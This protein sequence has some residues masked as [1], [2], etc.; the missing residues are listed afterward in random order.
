M[1]YIKKHFVIRSIKLFVSAAAL[2]F[3]AQAQ[4]EWTLNKDANGIKVY[5]KASEGS[6][7]KSIRATL[8]FD[9]PIS[10]VLAV[11]GDVKSFPEWV[12]KCKQTTLLKQISPTSAMFHHITEA[13]WPF[14]SRDHVSVYEMLRDDKTG[15]VT[16]KSHVISGVYP[17][18]KGY[19]RLKKSH[20][21]WIFTPV[22]DNKVVA[23]YE[24][25]FDPEGNIPAWLINMF[26]TEGPFQSLSKLKKRVHEQKYLDA[27][28]PFKK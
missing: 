26:I 14:D 16:M 11:V 25:S 15:V 3:Y 27:P 21:S 24:L 28:S 17:E 23:V 12:Y 8:E 5:T 9:V 19:V 7:I 6:P 20:A 13:P 22:G 1:E 2:L 18:Q 10:A 4:T